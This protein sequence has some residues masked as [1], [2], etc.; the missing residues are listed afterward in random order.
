MPIYNPISNSD[1]IQEGT[2]NK[3]YTDARAAG[4]RKPI[5]QLSTP[6]AIELAQQHIVVEN[7]EITFPAIMPEP[8]HISIVEFT[9]GATPAHNRNRCIG[10]KWIRGQHCLCRRCVCVRATGE[11]EV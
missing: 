4:K 9:S 2:T 1:L 11:Y 7:S 3:Y 5:I 10:A 8:T 6:P